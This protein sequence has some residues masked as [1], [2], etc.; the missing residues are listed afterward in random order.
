MEKLISKLKKEVLEVM[1]HRADRLSRGKR[2]LGK[3]FRW[4]KVKRELRKVKKIRQA[5]DE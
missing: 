5:L 2:F 4:H 1:N 3:W